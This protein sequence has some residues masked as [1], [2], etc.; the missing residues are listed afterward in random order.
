[1]ASINFGETEK[2]YEA[3]LKNLVINKDISNVVNIFS[4][5]SK[6]IFCEK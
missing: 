5:R 2:I 1:M 6:H 3:K 4:Q